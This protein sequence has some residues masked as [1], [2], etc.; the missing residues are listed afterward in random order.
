MDQTKKIKPEYFTQ[1][2]RGNFRKALDVMAPYQTFGDCLMLGVQLMEPFYF[3]FY[4]V[5]VTNMKSGALRQKCVNQIREKYQ[6]VF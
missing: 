6:A 3:C 5:Q 1:F 4:F 2:L